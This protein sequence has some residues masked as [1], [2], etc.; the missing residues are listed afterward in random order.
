MRLNHRISSIGGDVK[1]NQLSPAAHNDLNVIVFFFFKYNI[2]ILV[3]ILQYANCSV[4]VLK[5]LNNV[6]PSAYY[7]HQE[8]GVQSSSLFN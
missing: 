6:F 5:V 7:R 4:T 1:T 2:Y 3:K 8:I